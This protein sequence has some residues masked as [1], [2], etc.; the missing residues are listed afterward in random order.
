MQ[1]TYMFNNFI[2]VFPQ[3]RTYVYAV[4]IPYLLYYFR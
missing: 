1:D 2:V 3:V 4:E